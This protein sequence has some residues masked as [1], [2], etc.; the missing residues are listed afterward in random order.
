[1]NKRVV[2]RKKVIKPEIIKTEDE[3]ESDKI[4]HKAL[5]KLK[6]KNIKVK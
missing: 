3:I 4:L 1:M 6:G 5:L 2:K